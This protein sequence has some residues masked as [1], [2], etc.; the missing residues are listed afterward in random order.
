DATV[1]APKTDGQKPQMGLIDDA[2]GGVVNSIID[3]VKNS[4][5]EKVQELLPTIIA[6]KDF[7][8]LERCVDEAK[9]TE[10][11]R[12]ISKIF[13]G[14][15]QLKN[16]PKFRE[17]F[18]KYQKK[19]NEHSQDTPEVY[20]MYTKNSSDNSAN[21]NFETK[22]A[23][24]VSQMKQSQNLNNGINPKYITENS[25]DILEQMLNNPKF[26]EN[27]YMAS[28]AEEIIASCNTPEKASLC[29]K[30]I[31]NPKLYNIIA[32]TESLTTM[33][34]NCKTQEITQIRTKTIDDITKMLENNPD[35]ENNANFTSFAA[36]II[37]QTN[38][39]NKYSVAS[40][41]MNTP[42]F[43]E[44][45]NLRK[46]ISFI[47]DGIKTPEHANGVISVIDE[48][49]DIK[50]NHSELWNNHSFAEKRGQ[51]V[52]SAFNVETVKS[53]RS[54][55]DEIIQISEQHS[56]LFENEDF[57]NF[58]GSII[59]KSNTKEQA[60]AKIIA[61]HNITDIQENNP[62]LWN[63]KNFADNI[64]W[65]VDSTC[66]YNST[67]M[68]S[69]I[70][71]NP[72]VFENNDF[73]HNIG[74]FIF[75]SYRPDMFNQNLKV[76][77][78]I[79]GDDF[80]M[81]KFEN[82]D[83]KPKMGLIDEAQPDIEQTKKK[84][85]IN[86]KPQNVVL[87]N[88]KAIDDAVSKI[89]DEYLAAEQFLNDEFTK[90]GLDKIGIFHSRLKSPKSLK[91]KIVNYLKENPNATL[92]E[93]INDV[94]DAFGAR[95]ILASSDY[96]QHPE[97][98]ALI[99]AGDI[100]GAILKA[101]EIQ[102][103]PIY[104]GL[105]AFIISE[106][107]N[108][109]AFSITRLSNYVSEDGIPY[110]SEAQLANLRQLAASKNIEFNYVERVDENDPLYKVYQAQ[111]I[112]PTTRS[113]PSGYTAFQLNFTTKDGKTIEWQCRGDKVND[114]AEAE[115][116]PYD[117]RTHKEGTVKD[118]KLVRLYE[119]IDKILTDENH[120]DDDVYKAYQKY[121]A[122]YYTHLRKLELGFESTEP[123]LSDYEVKNVKFDKQLEA[124]N[125]MF[126]HDLTQKVKKGEIS[127]DDAI[128]IYKENL[129][130]N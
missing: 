126:I 118:P 28:H 110:L 104:E 78:D 99:D 31:E 30:I 40:K 119:P 74:H 38:T 50:E 17:F 29:K 43:Y 4:D 115:H 66:S 106:A 71:N 22:K 96:S 56:D 69:V 72:K 124:K 59:E 111:G 39:P 93:A 102:S 54:V 130:L 32:K 9:D 85:K 51:L 89:N 58:I 120:F 33:I 2:Q 26:L 70:L 7:A 62:D 123:K 16:D 97:V 5:I 15:P 128:K 117:I 109:T 44:D 67:N 95:T 19:W 63:N 92:P 34:D 11:L 113:Q 83:S 60:E 125:L 48:L 73:S 61:L 112:K 81:P 53:M 108:L 55:M 68:V 114:F 75:D 121:L 98:K 42:L 3:A 45:I 107:D 77:K 84:T 103:Q 37:A 20:N 10:I 6:N 91:D 24:L 90:L 86:E 8:T 100:R 36:Q 14:N 79:C 1:T 82:V 27:K 41:M 101:A 64:G 35:L 127:Q 18:D 25:I 80:V 47:I 94:R 105:K 46:Y 23:E 129:D 122:D 12:E 116:L 76:I 52:E 88:M 49:I 13:R 65:I 21:M 57:S 87:H